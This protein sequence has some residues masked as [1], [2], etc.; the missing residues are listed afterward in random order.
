VPQIML[1]FPPLL[2][3]L[4]SHVVAADALVYENVLHVDAVGSRVFVL[5][6]G[7]LAVRGGN[8]PVVAFAH[9]FKWIN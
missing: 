7:R 1:G 4:W 5:A 2:A 3:V 8:P 9:D 6:R